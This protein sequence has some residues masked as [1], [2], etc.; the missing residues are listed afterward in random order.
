MPG[1]AF[2]GLQV[3]LDQCAAIDKPLVVGEAGVRPIDVGGTLADRAAAI[4]AKLLR[5]VPA[6]V[7]GWLGWA[8]IKD[9]STLDNYDIGPG[10]PMLGVLSAFGDYEHAAGTVT[11][12]PGETTKTVTVKVRGDLLDELDETFQL[13]LSNAGGASVSGRHRRRHDRRRRRPAGAVD[14]RRLGARGRLGHDVGDVRRRADRPRAGGRSRSTS[15]PPGVTATAGVDFQSAVGHSHVRARPGAEDD[16][17][18][19][20]RRRDRRAERGL[21]GP[22]QRR[23]QRD[24]SRTAPASARSSPTTSTRLPSST[25]ARTPGSTRAR[26][27]P[28]PAPSPTRTRNTW[29]ATVDYGDG[30]G[31]QLLPLAPDKTFLLAHTY[32]DNGTFT[33][34][35]AV[36]DG[37]TSGIDSVS[38]VVGNVAPTVDAGPDATIATGAT[39]SSS[40]SFTDPG[41]DTWTAT[42]DYGDGTGVQPLTL[43]ANKTFALSHAY[44]ATGT[45][46][47]TVTVTD[48]DGGADSDTATVTV[49][50]RRPADAGD[51]RRPAGRGRPGPAD[52]HLHRH[53]HR[54]DR[55]DEQRRLRHGRRNG[56][57]NGRSGG[58][59]RPRRRR[60]R[61][62]HLPRPLQLRPDRPRR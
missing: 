32:A 57:R 58:R 52:R 14:R 62:R 27:S 56:D 16:H 59:R 12:A 33:V 4:R 19:R 13:L 15:R 21:R 50:G 6:G 35:V 24:R 38:V 48:D 20:Q 36:S 10:D 23:R 9:G 22:A 28:R 11:F 47:V 44:A 1:D 31:V 51:R 5:Q 37:A 7:E 45:F 55:R 34:T 17:R 3:R 26:P 46:T 25:P 42:V 54:P 61:H 41:A 8:W 2:N 43:A 30:S 60:Q 49:A 53:A 29:T 39:F 18:A 40:G